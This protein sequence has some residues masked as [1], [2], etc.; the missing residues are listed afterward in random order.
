MIGKGWIVWQFADKKD[1]SFFWKLIDNEMIV[2]I[3]QT[4]QF[5]LVEMSK[6][7]DKCE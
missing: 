5:I 4:K 3:A 6:V 1:N 2:Y 7:R